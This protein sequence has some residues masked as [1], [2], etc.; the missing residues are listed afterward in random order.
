M[1]TTIVVTTIFAP[2]F[3]ASYL[4]SICTAKMKSVV[5]VVIVPDRNTPMSVAEAASEARRKGFC[6]DCPSLESQEAFLM[7][8]GL[9]LDFIPFNSDNRRNV[10]FLMAIESGCDVLISIDDDNYCPSEC[11]FVREHQ[12]VGSAISAPLLTSSDQWANICTLLS[13]S[14][15]DLFPR[16]FPYSAQRMTRTTVLEPHPSPITV[17][18]NAGLWLDDPDVDAVHRLCRRPKINSFKGP[19][20]ILGPDVWSP[21]NTQNTSMTRDVALTYYYVR[22]GHPLQG[23]RIDRYGDILSGYLTQKCVKHLGQAIR[24]GTPIVEHRRTPHNLFKDLYHELAGM[25]IIEDFLPWLIDQQLEGN[26]CLD[27]YASLAARIEDDVETFRGFV[28]DDGG[29]EFLRATAQAMKTWIA[30]VRRWA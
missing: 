7:S 9:P 18:M 17:T 21:I 16:G 19:S 20:V 10:G 11:D 25:V 29:R 24:V 4:A 12:V 28:W 22:M 26:N 15:D 23:L 27:A 2:Q 1:N 13:G 6:V 5:R 3:L 14:T 8:I 30:A